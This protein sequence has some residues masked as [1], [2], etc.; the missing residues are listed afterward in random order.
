MQANGSRENIEKDEKG[1]TDN[2]PGLSATPGPSTVAE[3]G[4][5]SVLAEDRASPVLFH[6]I[7]SQRSILTVAVS[8]SELYA[9]T[10]EGEVLVWSLETYELLAKVR[11]HE[12]SVL[13]LFL[14]RGNQFLFSS[15]GDAIVN[16]WRTKG[17]K[18]VYS[19]YSTYDVGDVFCVVYS[20]L[21]ETI[22]LGAQNT[23]IQW[24]NISKKHA[25]PKVDPHRHPSHRNHRFFDSKGPGG[26][27][28]P[29]VSTPEPQAVEDCTFEIDQEHIHQYAHYGYVYC[30]LL[31]NDSIGG[32][33]SDQILVSGGGDGTIKLW[34]LDKSAVATIKNLRTLE[35][36]D[37]SIL[38]LAVDSTLLYSGRLGGD[39]NVW[40]LDTCQMVRRVQAHTEDVLTLAVG[41]GFIFSGSA[42]GFVKLT[43]WQQFNS[44][45]E[46]R[47]EWKAHNDLVL[48]SATTSYRGK[49]LYI[50]GGNDDCIA[51]WDVST[52]NKEPKMGMMTNNDQLLSSLAQLVSFRTIASRVEHAED[53]R[54]GA[55]WLRNLLKNFG[56]ETEMLRTEGNQNPVVFARFRCSVDKRAE[57]KPFL[58]YGHYDVVPADNREHTWSSD[59]FFMQARNGYLYG[60]GVT[61]NKGPVLAAIF[62]V[63]DLVAARQLTS[64]IVFLIE[65]EEECGSRGF[66]VA[67][68]KNKDLIG[69]INW[70]LLANSY[71]LNDDYPCL[72]YGLRGVVHATVRVESRHRDLHSG[73]DGSKLINESMKDLIS[74][75][76]ALTSSDGHIQIP[77]FYAPILPLTKAENERYKAISKTLLAA[78][79]EL[80]D[81]KELTRSFKARWREP[82]LTI[83]RISSSGSSSSSIIPRTA[84]AKLSIRLVPEQTSAEIKRSFRNVLEGAFENLRTSNLLTIDI[85]HEAEPWLGDPENKIFQTLEEAIMEVW[86]PIGHQRRGSLPAKKPQIEAL[87][88]SLSETKSTPV[89]SSTLS[90]GSDQ[91]SQA[92]LELAENGVSADSKRTV[93][94]RSQ[95]PLYIREGGSIPTI[96]FLEKEFGAPAAHLPC[97]QAS[98]SAHL[99]N[100]RLRLSNLYKSR[101]I[102]KKVFRELPLR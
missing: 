19:I 55:S 22:Y 32:I 35:N 47:H 28:F 63:A 15:A 66:Q 68:Q 20:D 2:E 6:K 11:A 45:Y 5:T 18:K 12:G 87:K 96:R 67:V 82:S 23:S 40:D 89:T 72:T 61:D 51:A 90:Q 76:A 29:R 93:K 101:D 7:K 98:D 94:D 41:H 43:Q 100:E 60:R 69:K 81:A 92:T 16:I 91:H 78:N 65:G 86:G 71:W 31:L 24:C 59:P 58:F 99:D 54:R 34:S 25:R 27:S 62:A 9:G 52:G 83:H 49:D 46:C 85:D 42:S 38:S 30:M 75:L 39:I 17:L 53:C 84:T 13:C 64:D 79:P 1:T 50:T 56:A 3:K 95:K 44:R 102:F 26:F 4:I 14:S 77:N 88:D 8:E 33:A 10:E 37:D 97:G 74:I 73:V 80:G 48:A 21:L 57:N 36:G 70:I